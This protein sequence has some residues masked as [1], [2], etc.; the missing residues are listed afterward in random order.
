[1]T[2]L[3]RNAVA[4]VGLVT[5]L[6]AGGLFVAHALRETPPPP[7][8]TVAVQPVA[9]G[10]AV[11]PTVKAVSFAGTSVTAT[12]AGLP[13]LA[14]KRAHLESG[15]ADE[16]QQI[17]G[18]PHA[19]WE[20]RTGTLLP[21]P[22]GLP[23]TPVT[24]H[25]RDRSIRQALADLGK[26]A[27]VKLVIFPPYQLQQM[28]F[29]KV[30]L[31]ADGRPLLEVLN[32]F[33]AK[34]GLTAGTRPM[35][36]AGGPASADPASPVLGLQPL[37]IDG[38]F[39]PWVVSGP[40]AFEVQRVS[41]LAPI[42]TGPE[43]SGDSLTVTLSVQH[44][45]QLVVL[46]QDFQSAVTTAADEAGHSLVPAVAP[47]PP[48]PAPIGRGSI[49][50][51]LFGGRQTSVKTFAVG[52]QA[53]EGTVDLPLACPPT[54]GRRIAMLR[55]NPR[56]VVQAKSERVETPVGAAA[57]EKTIGGISVRIGPSLGSPAVN[58]PVVFTRVHQT[59]V[60]WAQMRSALS[61]VVPVMVDD[62]GHALPVP[63]RNGRQDNDMSITAQF[64][65]YQ[66]QYYGSPILK[67]AKLVIDV[68][69][70]LRSVEVPVEFK[71]LPLP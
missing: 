63:Q 62:H 65:W 44:E 17:T 41:H 59:D 33:C 20:D 8:P 34:T 27:G 53:P 60:E 57:V 15:P 5:V 14:E 42:A 10:V 7:H 47:A 16:G 21:Q 66:Q 38:G 70:A 45:P 67:P 1:M 69:T 61:N 54:V 50:S 46:G 2:H 29:P 49:L 37:E 3:E 64:Y 32:E 35:R 22:A 9:P 68:P 40:F 26:A 43:P 23:A 31:D 30:T 55:L 18:H 52:R 11:E 4:V 13:T 58:C 6:W 36:Y 48:P 28:P 56:F 19:R 39:G 24:V 12:D 25:L 51:R 71:D